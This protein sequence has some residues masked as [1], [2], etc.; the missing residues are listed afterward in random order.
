MDEIACRLCFPDAVDYGELV[1]EY[2]MF[3]SEGEFF[4]CSGNG[5]TKLAK[6]QGTPSPDPFNG[7]TEKQIEEL[8]DGALSEWF[9]WAVLARNIEILIKDE[10]GI[11]DFGVACELGIACVEAGW[12]REQS[13][14]PAFWLYERAGNLILK[15]R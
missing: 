14:S 4:I 15:N 9:D 7:L 5:H 2:F 1:P 6:F 13:G 11:T 3:Q 10:N 12:T 8:P